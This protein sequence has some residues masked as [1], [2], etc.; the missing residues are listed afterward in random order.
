VEVPT[1]DGPMELEIK[2]GSQN[3]DILKLREKGV[4]YLQ[5]NG[6]GDQLVNL[7]VVVPKKLTEEQ[8]RLLTELSKTMPREK[9]GKTV[10]E[11]EHEEKGFFGRI[12]DA[13]GSN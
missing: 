3:G 9:I 6:R 1:V 10:A 8:R 13:L 2:P 4:P 11:R 5:G 7:R 12:K